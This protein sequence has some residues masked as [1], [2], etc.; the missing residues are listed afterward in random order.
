MGFCPTESGPHVGR[1]VKQE[2]TLQGYSGGT[3]LEFSILEP[4]CPLPELAL[5]PLPNPGCASPTLSSQPHHSLP[6][7][8]SQQ[9][10]RNLAAASRC[11]SHPAPPPWPRPLTQVRPQ[12]CP[13]R[14]L[15]LDHHGT[16]PSMKGNS[17]Q[18][19]DQRTFVEQVRECKDNSYLLSFKKIGSGAFSK[20]YLAYATH[21]HLQHNPKLSSVQAG[22]TPGLPPSPRGPSASQPG[23][24]RPLCVAIK[25]ITTAKAL[26]EFSHKFLPCEISS[27]NATYKHL[28][29][30]GRGLD[31]ACPHPVGKLALPRLL[32]APGL[33]PPPTLD[34]PLAPGLELNP[35]LE[36]RSGAS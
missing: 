27:L 34:L 20:V 7:P 18:K 35:T 22:A 2:D 4:A 12:L 31:T 8:Q 1:S 26:V 6:L 11:S 13:P 5:P 33:W 24:S 21:E 36:P 23:P 14:L 10:L 25:I 32:P 29:V 17:R 19:L 9:A 30:V 3:A 15:K 28:N 16:L